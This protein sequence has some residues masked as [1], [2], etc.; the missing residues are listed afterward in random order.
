MKSPRYFLYA[1]LIIALIFL[2]S[3][4]SDQ[5]PAAPSTVS[6]S[7]EKAAPK[8]PEL[9]TAMQALNK[10]QGYAQKQWAADA[11]PIDISSEP[12]AEANGQDGKATVW[13][14][15]FGS[16]QRGEV[17]TFRWSGSLLP[18]APVKGV[19]GAASSSALTPEFAAHMFQ[20]FLFKT[21]SDKA[22]EVAQGH[23]AK[24]VLTKNPNQEVRYVVVFDPKLNAPTVWVVFG[25]SVQKNNGYGIINGLTG[26]FVRGGKA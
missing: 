26:T 21:D 14:G 19:S 20:G 11:M 24:D 25:E 7:S 10:M 4:S 1:L 18:D 2:V 8:T 3:C 13:K 17:R 16:S 9:V 5:K 6:A 22:I 15:V 23:G 12:N